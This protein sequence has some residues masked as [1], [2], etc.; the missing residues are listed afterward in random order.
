MDKFL[1]SNSDVRPSRIAAVQAATKLTQSVDGSSDSGAAEQDEA[2]AAPVE[3]VEEGAPVDASP[4]ELSLLKG[5]AL[6]DLASSVLSKRP[7]PPAAA[8]STAAKKPRPNKG[9]PTHEQ[10]RRALGDAVSAKI[11]FTKWAIAARTHAHVAMDS[12]CFESVVRPHASSVVPSG[13]VTE[14]TP[15]VVARLSSTIA[16]GEVFGK[17]KIRDGSRMQQWSADVCDVIWH[18]ATQTADLWWTMA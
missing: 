11:H 1:I 10:M 9:G 5:Q 2:Y 8:P 13:A 7:A 12:R 16:C 18:P 14:D 15:V 6:M 17:T 3:A 4:P